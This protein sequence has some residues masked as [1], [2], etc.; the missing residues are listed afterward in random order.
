M[1]YASTSPSFIGDP[2]SAT[3]ELEYVE[4]TKIQDMTSSGISRRHFAKKLVAMFFTEEDQS[5]CSVNG[6]NKQKLD[7]FCITYVKSKTFQMYPL[8]P[9][10]EKIEK[11]WSECVITMDEENRRLNRKNKA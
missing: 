7:L 5:T 9:Q 2:T 1:W 3:L 11:A 6:R 10:I 8:N 4:Q